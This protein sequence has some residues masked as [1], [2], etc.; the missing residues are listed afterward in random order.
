MGTNGDPPEIDADAGGAADQWLVRC[1]K[2]ASSNLQIA[3]TQLW[4][5][6]TPGA[7]TKSVD[8]ARSGQS[9]E[10]APSPELETAN[11]SDEG[12]AVTVSLACGGCGHKTKLVIG[13][14][15]AFARERSTQSTDSAIHLSGA[16]L[17]RLLQEEGE[18]QSGPPPRERTAL[19]ALIHRLQSEINPS[20]EESLAAN[21]HYD[22][23]ATERQVR[24]LR[25][26]TG[27]CDSDLIEV[28]IA[29]GR[30]HGA[31]HDCLHTPNA[32]YR[33]TRREASAL[34]EISRV[35]DIHGSDSD[36]RKPQSPT[37]VRA[38]GNVIQLRP[39]QR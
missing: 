18:K 4:M 17:R 11:P 9:C 13:E 3:Q 30:L 14:A 1:P 24:A 32:L 20:R 25:N 26:Y 31:C 39:R 2:C 27:L 33:L 21:H 7:Q 19:E 22:R 8:I 6:S 23:G 36:A 34:F 37:Q 5:R 28:G 38:K 12:S 15:L 10:R 16:P 35:L 29:T